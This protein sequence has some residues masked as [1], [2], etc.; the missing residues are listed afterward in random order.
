MFFYNEK[1]PSVVVVINNL[2]LSINSSSLAFQDTCVGDTSQKA[3]TV[4]ATGDT[5]ETVVVSDNTNQFSF[6]PSSFSISKTGS[7]IVTVTFT[8]TSW[9]AKTGT[10]T[11]SSSGGDTKTVSLDGTCVASA[12]V[13]TSSVNSINFGNGYVNETSSSTFTVSAG[14]NVQGT[15]TLSDNSNQFDFSPASFSFTGSNQSQT[16]TASFTPTSTGSKTGILTL[17]SSDG[18]TKAISL[19]GSGVYRALVLT[20][21]I[22]SI[23]FGRGYI[24]ETSNSTFTVSAGGIGGTETVTLSDDSNQ[25]SFSPSSFSLT[26]GGSSQNVT[27]SFTP[28]TT[29]T[30]TATLT[31]NSS[32]GSTKSISL[33][34]S[35]SYHD[36]LELNSS[37]DSIEFP[38]IFVT[39]KIG[40]AHV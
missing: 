17:S 30:K 34:G 6:S 23:N 21:S 38:H 4:T 15:V 9:G 35:G 24:N 22:S 20:S 39:Q 37:L 28:T 29:G 32:G 1:D 10:I 16:V 19:T 5:T 2:T 31:L 12:L 26:G 13:I 40:R 18:G 7:Q 8:P 25:F 3:F 33:T 27:A 11:L 36:P 14:G